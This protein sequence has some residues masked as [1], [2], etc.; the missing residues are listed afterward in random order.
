LLYLSNRIDGIFPNYEM[1][2]PKEFPIDS[3]QPEPVYGSGQPCGPVV[4]RTQ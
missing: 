1:V 3:A 4:R 2:I